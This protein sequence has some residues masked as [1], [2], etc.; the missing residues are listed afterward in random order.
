MSVSNDEINRKSKKPNTILLVFFVTDFDSE[1]E[2]PLFVS[3]YPDIQ[4]PE[5]IKIQSFG[6][7]NG[8]SSEG[9]KYKVISEADTNIP[10]IGFEVLSE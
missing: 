2:V 4:L 9:L 7:L 8:S 3:K 1:S 10:Q 6:E 5:I